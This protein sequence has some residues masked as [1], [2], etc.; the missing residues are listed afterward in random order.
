MTVATTARPQPG[1]P[2]AY[3]FPSFERDKLANGVQLVVAPVHKL[4]LVTVVAVL[5]AGAVS[6]PAGREGLAQLT[7]QLLLEG[8]ARADAAH[9]VER[10]ERLG[11]SV[12]A[13]ADWDVATVGMTVVSGRLPA[14]LALFG[15][16]L[17]E[18]AFPE[19]EVERLKAERL[20]ELLQLRTEPRGLADEMF[21]RFTYA[22]RSRFALPA[23]GTEASVAAVMR[24]D[25]QRFYAARYRPGGTTL[26]VVGDVRAA[27]VERLTATAFGDWTGGA[28]ERA[29]PSDEPAR[30]ARAVHL[31]AK[32]DAPQS[33]LRIGH[34][35]VPR[36]HP[37]YFSIVVMNA[38]LGGLFSSRINLN[39]REAHGYTYGA[40]SEYDW[41]R[42]AGPFV[43]STAVRSDVTDAAAREVLRE[44]DRIRAADVDASELSL[45]TSYLDGVFPIRY[46]TTAAIA[47]AL[48]NLVIYGLPEDYFDTYRERVRAVGAGEVRRAAERHLHP[49][50]LQLVV[51][52][53]AVAA[54]S[55]LEAL[56]SGPVRLYDAEGN[57]I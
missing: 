11:T 52:G 38:V 16:V 31:V 17:R 50:E 24:A 19:R 6:D 42:A 40:H 46:E 41:R 34:V 44:I 5:E 51:V 9:L 39:L 22:P 2:R 53:D 8:T 3:H 47:A 48:T 13:T 32:A 21:S 57:E 7:A 10:L 54:R 1:P 43:V 12:S 23:G 30:R 26:V 27:E 29:S 35:G 15:E 45:A 20:A 36:T 33:E 37:D 56:G 28:P 55:P 49:E 18:P 14:A 4:P 25:V